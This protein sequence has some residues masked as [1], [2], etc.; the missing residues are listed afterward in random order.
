MPLHKSEEGWRRFRVRTGNGHMARRAYMDARP[1]GRLAAAK[2]KLV[3][4][5]ERDFAREERN[6]SRLMSNRRR[7]VIDE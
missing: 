3:E 2:P 4:P 7:V 6:E 1:T 5:S